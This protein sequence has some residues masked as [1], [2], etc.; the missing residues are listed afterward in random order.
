MLNVKASNVTAQENKKSKPFFHDKMLCPW[1]VQI[2]VMCIIAIMAKWSYTIVVTKYSYI[3]ALIKLL[4][5]I[6][7]CT[8]FAFW[9]ENSVYRCGNNSIFMDTFW[10]ITDDEY[11]DEE[12]SA[13][14]SKMKTST[15][16]LKD[17]VLLYHVPGTSVPGNNWHRIHFFHTLCITSSRKH[18]STRLSIS[19][20]V[21]DPDDA[22]SGELET[23]E[24]L[25]LYNSTKLPGCDEGDAP[26]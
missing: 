5:R 6:R 23:E 22:D 15:T 17:Q 12:L 10:E 19:T 16:I 20:A 25:S 11:G 18:W 13:F 24:P 2:S 3:T 26:E 7:I 9:L 1:Y 14:W 21:C 4:N 8:R